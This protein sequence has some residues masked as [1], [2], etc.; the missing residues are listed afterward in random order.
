[1]I[2]GGEVGEDTS[3]LFLKKQTGTGNLTGS[4]I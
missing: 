2:K 4:M 3:P 1:M